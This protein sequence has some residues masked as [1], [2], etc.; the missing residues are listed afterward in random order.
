MRTKDSVFI[1][2]DDIKEPPKT[3]GEVA[4]L[5]HHVASFITEKYFRKPMELEFEKIFTFFK[6]Y[7][8]KRYH[9]LQYEPDPAETRARGRIVLAEPKVEAKGVILERRD[10]APIAR[11]L[12]EKINRLHILGGKDALKESVEYLRATVQRVVDSAKH[13]MDLKELGITK[14][15]AAEYV[16]PYGHPHSAVAEKMRAR[17][18]VVNPNEHVTYVVLEDV[19]ME[20]LP[21]SMQRAIYEKKANPATLS[22]T[23]RAEDINFATANSLHIDRHYYLQQIKTPVYLAFNLPGVPEPVQAEVR[24]IIETALAKTKVATSTA[25]GGRGKSSIGIRLLAARRNVWVDDKAFGEGSAMSTALQKAIIRELAHFQTKHLAT[26]EKCCGADFQLKVDFASTQCKQVHLGNP[27]LR[28]PTPTMQFCM[29]HGRVHNRTATNGSVPFELQ[30]TLSGGVRFQCMKAGAGAAWPS[31]ETVDATASDERIQD[32]RLRQLL[33]DARKCIRDDTRQ[34]EEEQARKTAASRVKREE[35]K[36]KRKAEDGA[37]VTMKG[38]RTMNAP[39]ATAALKKAKVTKSAEAA[40]TSN[41]AK[42]Q[43]TQTLTSF[44]TKKTKT[45]PIDMS[46]S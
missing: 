28:L 24:E 8:K 32:P 35:T 46:I 38:T 41:T 11:A 45:T 2:F 23:F 18:L 16:N 1:N 42:P 6:Q 27:I 43:K 13:G 25:A 44:F 5:G 3:L 26:L 36:K 17:G 31:R 29:A 10:G 15:V 9:G 20:S 7:G 14:R 19:K 40:R 34:Q 4:Q 30:I 22:V 12:Y 39:T 37:A 33:Q 21:E